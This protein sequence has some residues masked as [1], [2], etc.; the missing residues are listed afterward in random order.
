[1]KLETLYTIYKFK[2]I[3]IKRHFIFS[4]KRKIKIIEL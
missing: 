3:V 2:L 1:M 4:E